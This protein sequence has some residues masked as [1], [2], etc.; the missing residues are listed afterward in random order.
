MIET[1]KD[2]F[3]T[4]LFSIIL[5]IGVL[6]GLLR[7]AQTDRLREANRCTNAA[8]WTLL[9]ALVGGRIAY[10]IPHWAYFQNYPLQIPKIWLGGMA[11]SGAL[12]GGILAMTIIALVTRQHLGKM[13]DALLPLLSITSASIW[14]GCW[15]SGVAYGPEVD[16]WWAL[17]AK[18]YQGVVSDRF[19]LQIIAAL[20]ILLLFWGI[21]RL[22]VRGRLSYPGM[23]PISGLGASIGLAALSLV[24]LGAS[25]LRVD[26]TPLWNGIHPDTWLS[27]G[28]VILSL[29]ACLTLIV[30][31]RIMARKL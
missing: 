26:P 24:Q 28:F 10:L 23:V 5:G 30:H 9:G 14:L 16:A 15:L 25:F 17:P 12:A 21:D 2:T 18:D 4:N 6:I 22:R 20:S 7:I 31:S 11:W 13:A 3:S 27:S 1:V 8:L 19:P 29:V